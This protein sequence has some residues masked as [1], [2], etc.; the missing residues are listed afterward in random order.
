[1]AQ[2][3]STEVALQKVMCTCTGKAYVSHVTNGAQR[4][5]ACTAGSGTNC[6]PSTSAAGAAVAAANAAAATFMGP[7][8][9]GGVERMRFPHCQTHTLLI[10]RYIDALSEDTTRSSFIHALNHPY[11]LLVPPLLVLLL[12]P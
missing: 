5:C 12:L 2:L 7:P 10:N 9:V 4:N 6:I 11:Q 1:V 3:T 8:T